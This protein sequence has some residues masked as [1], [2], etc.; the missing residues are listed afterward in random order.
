MRG[1]GANLRAMAV[2]EGPGGAELAGGK[3]RETVTGETVRDEKR[4]R[5]EP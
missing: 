5:M 4:L 1:E 2:W 3:E